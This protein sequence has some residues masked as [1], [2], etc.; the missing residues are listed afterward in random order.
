[1][2]YRFNHEVISRETRQSSHLALD[3]PRTNHAKQSFIYGS[4]QLYNNACVNMG[5]VD[6]TSV[7]GGG[8][9]KKSSDRPRRE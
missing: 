1:M 4:S 5:D 2:T 9:V 8:D 7:I 3:K 6:F